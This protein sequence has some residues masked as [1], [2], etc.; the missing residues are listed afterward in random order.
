MDFAWS[1][2]GRSDVDNIV[3]RRTSTSISNK[4][5]PT[6]FCFLILLRLVFQNDFKCSFEVIFLVTPIAVTRWTNCFVCCSC[7]TSWHALGETPV[8]SLDLDAITPSRGVCWAMSCYCRMGEKD[9]NEKWQVLRSILLTTSHNAKNNSQHAH[10]TKHISC[11]VELQV[12]CVSNGS[13]IHSKL[14]W[15]GLFV[16]SETLNWTTADIICLIDIKSKFFIGKVS[17]WCLSQPISG[18]LHESHDNQ[19]VVT[20]GFSY[21][22]EWNESQISE[23]ELFILI[24]RTNIDIYY[25]ACLDMVHI[26]Q[27]PTFCPTTRST[28]DRMVNA[29]TKYFSPIPPGKYGKLAEHST[30]WQPQPNEGMSRLGTLSV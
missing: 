19:Q 30:L 25:T 24:K 18:I 5:I 4:S 1:S 26:F 9:D 16:H 23:Y 2:V 27:H 13:A 20:F 29:L 10:S 22:C 3:S 14:V 15:C 12:A 21:Y 6:A 11:W 17:C 28:H 8:S 7:V